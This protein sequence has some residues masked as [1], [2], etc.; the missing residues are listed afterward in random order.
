MT[1]RGVGPYDDEFHGEIRAHRG[2]WDGDAEDDHEGY[3]EYEPGYGGEIDPDVWPQVAE[4]RPA[5]PARAGNGRGGGGGR[6]RGRRRRSH[7][8][9]TALAILVVILI[10]VVAGGLVGAQGQINPGGKRGAPVSV[11]IPKGSSTQQIG[12][13]L[14]AAGIIHN[15]TLFALYVRIHGDGPL[16]PGSYVLDRNLPYSAA[17][18]ALEAGPKIITDKLLIPEGYTEAQIAAAVGRLPGMGLSPQKFM[19]A[20]DNGTVRSPFEPTGVNDLEGLLFPATY[21]VQQGET[22]VQILEQLVGEFTTQAN[23]IG[24]MADAANLKVTPYQLIT[25]ASIVEREA[26]LAG[27][28]P[29]VASA[30]YNRLKIG[31]TLGADSTQTYY[32]RLSDPTVEPTVAQLNQASPYNTRLNKGLPPTPIANPGLASLQAAAT[33]ANTTY[34]YFVEIN[35]DGQLGFAS[36]NS[37]FAGLQRQCQ[38]AGLC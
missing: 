34:L 10:V 21:P 37:G 35:P 36:T 38:A 32:L 18:S 11:V 14:A 9:L 4:R 30:I 15:S 27:D 2:E 22:E 19:A 23:Q 7:P 6:N 28:R 29:D 33:P 3:E 8:I 20:I 16:Y 25:V 1:E 12:K 31:M 17:I 5:R 24:L 13:R 26:K